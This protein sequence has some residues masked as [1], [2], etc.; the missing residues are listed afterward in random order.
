MTTRNEIATRDGVTS[1]HGRQ[2]VEV[3]R[4]TAILHGL[5]A[6][7]HGMRLTRGV[8][9]TKVAKELTG[10]RTNDRAKLAAAVELLREQARAACTDR[11]KLAVA[12]EQAALAGV[13]K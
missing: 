12:H 8:S 11:A 3:Y 1:F 2:A 7:A 9:C 10:L 6:E 13:L 5:R 4:L